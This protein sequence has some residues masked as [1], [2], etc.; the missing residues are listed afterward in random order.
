MIGERVLRRIAAGGGEDGMVW[1]F[2]GRICATDGSVVYVV[3][4]GDLGGIGPPEDPQRAARLA[5]DID[6]L[7]ALEPCPVSPIGAWWDALRPEVCP[8]CHGT[9]VCDVCEE[10]EL[11]RR[12]YGG[13]RVSEDIAWRGVVVPGTVALLLLDLPGLLVETAP[14]N[15]MAF[16]AEDGA[17]RGVVTTWRHRG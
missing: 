10:G 11:C 16:S 5:R 1:A 6:R 12:C 9:G 14:V 2:G 13:G 4:R 8:V 3:T 17:I 7:I 15:T